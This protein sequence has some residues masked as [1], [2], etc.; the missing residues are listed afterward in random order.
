MNW[1]LLTPHHGNSKASRTINHIL[2]S[3]S[4]I[5]LHEHRGTLTLIPPHTLCPWLTVT[6]H[7]LTPLPLWQFPGNRLHDPVLLLSSAPLQRNHWHVFTLTQRSQ[8][9]GITNLGEKQSI[10]E[11]QQQGNVTVRSQCP[12]LSIGTLR[13]DCSTGVELQGPQTEGT[14]WLQLYPIRTFNPPACTHGGRGQM[15]GQGV[16][17]WKCEREREREVSPSVVSAQ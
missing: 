2:V 4:C 7:V 13:D 1:N 14:D 6:S 3:A 11:G 9:M 12:P 16:V 10:W 5:T 8:D 17:G 15:H